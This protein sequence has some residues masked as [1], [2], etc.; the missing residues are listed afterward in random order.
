VLF[1]VLV[2]AA[3]STASDYTWYEIGVEH[4]MAT[5]IVTGVV[6]LMA[7]GGA[8]GWAVGRVVP[9]LWLGVVAGLIGAL[10]YY[11]LV[12]ALGQ[13]AMIAAWASLWI[14]LAIGEGRLIRPGR[15]PWADAVARGVVAAVASGLAFYLV[16]DDLW[17][18]PPAGG[19]NYALQFGRWLIAWAPGIL[20]IALPPRGR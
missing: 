1:G 2:V 9:G 14:I 7:V 13:R 10:A 19:R 15:R 12:P 6:M 3:V 17:G 20:A 18:R 5:G 4:R 16:A 11:A 8:L